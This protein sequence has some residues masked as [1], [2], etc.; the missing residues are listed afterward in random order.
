MKCNPTYLLLLVDVGFPCVNPTYGLIEP[1]RDEEHEGRKK[2]KISNI[3]LGREYNGCGLFVQ[4]K[5][6]I[7]LCTYKEFKYLIFGL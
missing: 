5:H 7:Y 2:K 1:R 3:A 6:Y 4:L